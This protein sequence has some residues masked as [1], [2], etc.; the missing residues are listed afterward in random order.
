MSANRK[1]LL[2]RYY[3]DPL[4]RL[5]DC[6]PSAQARTQRFYLKERLNSE[7][8]G[9]VQR[10]VFQQDDQLLAQQ[11]RQDGVVETTLLTTDQQRSVLHALD[12]TQP[13]PLT[14]TP[15]GH[16]PAENGLL[17]LLGINGER[18]DP[19]TGHY[20]LGNGYRA[21]NP[22]LMRFNSPDTWSPFGEGGL[23][24]FG[25]CKGDPVNQNDPTGH[26]PLSWLRGFV[27]KIARTN[28]NNQTVG[29]TTSGDVAE[30][31]R[32][33][34]NLRAQTLDYESQLAGWAIKEKKAFTLKIN[35]K[36]DLRILKNKN[37]KYKFILTDEQELII[38]GIKKN[39]N[40]KILSHPFI[41]TQTKTSNI[42]SAG[43]M[44]RTANR[45]QIINKSGHYHPALSNLLPTK[46]HIES[47]GKRVNT[48][49]N[50]GSSKL[51][52]S[53]LN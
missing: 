49:R 18:P 22:V 36:S 1:T 15:Y 12:A 23:N 9:S 16:R 44:T 39:Q 6:T 21:F 38:G 34:T 10:S 46:Q 8:Q 52:Y 41:A 13:H 27:R 29:A 30:Q 42:I 25:Y 20:L 26:S 2:C 35:N 28:V 51:I 32:R 47:L 5:A 33:L 48:I 19:V 24:A 31:P 7:I 11:R 3:Y 45:I 43:H 14:Y 37:Y 40:T 53:L 50:E 4:D 17:S